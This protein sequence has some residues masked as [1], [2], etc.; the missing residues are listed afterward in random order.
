M[1]IKYLNNFKYLNINVLHLV[2]TYTKS[3]LTSNLNKVTNKKQLP[4]KY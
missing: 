2:S 3:N 1:Y 4:S